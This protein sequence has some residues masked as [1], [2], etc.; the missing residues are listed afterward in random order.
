MSWGED[1]LND[2]KEINLF[3]DSMYVRLSDSVVLIVSPT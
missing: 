3:I 1:Y 2:L